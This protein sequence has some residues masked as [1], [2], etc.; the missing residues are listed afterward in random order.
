VPPHGWRLPGRLRLVEG[1]SAGIAQC[2]AHAGVGLCPTLTLCAKFAQSP[3]H[4]RGG[5]GIGMCRGVLFWFLSQIPHVRATTNKKTS[6]P[7]RAGL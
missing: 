5:I 6:W 4:E 3:A 7:T 2:P 1:L